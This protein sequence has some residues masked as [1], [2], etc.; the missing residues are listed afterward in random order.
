MWLG[1]CHFSS[2]L[3]GLYFHQ[4]FKWFLTS[5]QRV[6]LTPERQDKWIIYSQYIQW[7]QV[8]GLCALWLRSRTGSPPFPTF[9]ADANSKEAPVWRKAHLY[10]TCCLSKW[11]GSGLLIEWGS[12]ALNLQL[13]I[14]LRWT[15]LLFPW[16][17]ISPTVKPG[18]ADCMAAHSTSLFRNVM[19]CQCLSYIYFLQPVPHQQESSTNSCGCVGMAPVLWPVMVQSSTL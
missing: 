14:F 17:L 2:R 1:V 10:E 12:S 18:S 3:H 5:S 4:V 13:F 7:Q 6:N 9:P 15:L 8:G 19:L 11:Q 16:N